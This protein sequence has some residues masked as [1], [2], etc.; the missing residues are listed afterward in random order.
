MNRIETTARADDEDS[1]WLALER[2]ADGATFVY[3]VRTTGVYCRVGCH[4]RRPNRANVRFFDDA[5]AAERAG[6]RPC[7]RCGGAVDRP[8]PSPAIAAACRR[9]EAEGRPRGLADLAG[10][11][12]LSPSRFAAEFRRQ[13]GLTPAGFARAARGRKLREG[14]AGSA[15]VARAILGA[16]YG[17]IGRGY[18]AAA[19]E[20]GMTPA[21]YR[22][23]GEG[24][25]I[26]FGSARSALGWVLAASTDLGLCWIELGD[27]P[28]ALEANLRA[29]FPRAD[30]VGDDPGFADAVRRV[31]ARVESPS[32]AFDLPLDVRGSAFQRRVWD[33]LGAIPLGRTAT[34]AEI[35]RA[36]GHP[37]AARAVAG[38]CAANELAVV[39]PCHRV[40]RGDGGP[41]GYRWGVERK[42]SL[43]A[44]EA[45]AEA[46]AGD[47]VPPTDPAD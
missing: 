26:R 8:P 44:I 35:A 19:G 20:L 15:S 39:V 47:P 1:R 36:I 10:S 12:G 5:E 13:V 34:Y 7:K 37:S 24:E 4:S 21:R 17:S 41:G 33:A 28:D 45:E 14:L 3:A 31:V 11:S 46:G 6:Y 23:G 30:L 42:R 40:V 43:L 2:K 27:G 38:A 16:G 22:S 18:E 29:R 32:V 25:R 9:I